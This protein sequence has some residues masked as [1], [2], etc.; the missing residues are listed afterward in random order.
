MVSIKKRG[1]KK[2]EKGGKGKERGL[3]MAVLAFI[4]AVIALVVAVL[5][6]QRAEGSK[7]L[8]TQLNSLREKTADALSKVEKALRREDKKDQ[9]GSNESNSE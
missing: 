2:S 3:I 9:P 8:K 6:Y 5:A 4:I 1:K 7:D